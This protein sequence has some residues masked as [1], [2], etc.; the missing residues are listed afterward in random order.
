MTARRFITVCLALLTIAFA[1]GGASAQL[2][3]KKTLSLAAAKKMA[4]AAEAEAAKNKWTMVIAVLDDGGHLIYLEQMDGAQIGSIEVAQGKARTAVRFRRPSKD[5]EDAVTA[6]HLGVMTLG[7]ITA[8]RGGLPVMVDGKAAGAI[9]V[10]GGDAE[11]D[12]QCA[13]AGLAALH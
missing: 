10:S 9:G 11:Q 1:S 5:F 7:D 8:I 6:N 12:E 4:A 3:T 2:L 13:E